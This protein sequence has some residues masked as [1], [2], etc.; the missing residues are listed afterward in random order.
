MDTEMQRGL[1]PGAMALSAKFVPVVQRVSQRTVE[2]VKDFVADPKALS[3]KV[4]R[5]PSAPCLVPAT[6]PCCFSALLIPAGLKDLGS[7]LCYFEKSRMER[8]DMP[9]SIVK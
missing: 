3:D 9:P 4:F 7:P 5:H 6:C 1:L 2:A 8:R